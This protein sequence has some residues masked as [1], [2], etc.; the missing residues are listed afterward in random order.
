MKKL[1]VT[2]SFLL[3]AAMTFA[4]SGK[5]ELNNAYNAYSNGYLDRA[6]T[7]INKCMEYED[8]K[9]DAKTWMYR[10]NIFLQIADT[11][12]AEY[13]ALSNNA[14]EE[15][16]ESYKKALELDPNVSVGMRIATPAVGL[17]FCSQM[18]IQ[19]AVDILKS[20]QNLDRAV[21]LAEKSHLADKS[22]DNNT[23]IYGYCAEMAG[24]KDIAKKC[25]TSLVNK[26]TKLNIFPY[27]RL[28]SLFKDENDTAH[29]I[30]VVQICESIFL[31][32]EKYD[33]NAA[34]SASIIYM[35]AGQNDKATELMTQA[36]EKDPNNHT[37]L[38]N[39]GSELTNQKHYSEAEKYLKKA[40][41]LQ[42]ND[43]YVNYNLGN[44]YYN[45]YVDHYK[46]LDNIEDDAAYEAAKTEME[47]LLNNSRP[48]LEKAH[49]IEPND[50]NTL[51]ML[52][53]IYSRIP[54][55]EK[56]LDAVNQQLNALK[57]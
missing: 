43:F 30:K 37:L 46:D 8:T 23:Y 25:Y 21:T 6:L 44:C 32:P 5:R 56:E 3:I 16:F 12:D 53:L 17:K 7:A 10:G 14:A 31:T 15:A 29:A 33:V 57:K 13:K 18:L 35:W 45:N 24:K 26:K 20:G 19:E 9:N 48:Y 41:E 51:I 38:I 28:A 22:D 11:K 4:Q 2:W 1:V 50:N 42:P 36:L 52:K 55:A 40:L 47:K 39:Y 49:E 34:T 54:G 27:V